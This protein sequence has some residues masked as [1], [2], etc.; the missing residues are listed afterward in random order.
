VQTWVDLKFADGE[1]RFALGLAQISEIER[2]C[3]AGIGEIYARVLAGRYG[4]GVDDILPT[5]A[6]Y[7]VSDLVEVIRQMLIGGGRGEVDGSE[8]KVSSIRANDLLNSYVLAMSD[9]RMA[10]REVWALAAAGLSALIEG[11]T[12]PKKDLPGDGPATPQSG[13]ITPPPSPTA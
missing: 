7:K 3:D 4:L 5:E 12:P 1:Y 9:Q 6:R 11:Y 10:M 8:V 2:K 13:S